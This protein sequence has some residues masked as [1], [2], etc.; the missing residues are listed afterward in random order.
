MYYYK[1]FFKFVKNSL[2]YLLLN[3]L[4]FI[5]YKNNILFIKRF[6]YLLFH[7]LKYLLGSLLMSNKPIV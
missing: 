5:L 7:Q 3:L 6:F 1:I 4:N 2:E